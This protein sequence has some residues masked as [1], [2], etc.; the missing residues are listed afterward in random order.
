MIF[1]GT[2][3]THE[4]VVLQ[5]YILRLLQNRSGSNK[6]LVSKAEDVD[7]GKRTQILLL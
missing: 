2:T 7:K 1:I 5:K 4:T 6:A 3:A